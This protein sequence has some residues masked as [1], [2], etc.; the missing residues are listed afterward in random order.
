MSAQQKNLIF[1]ATY[2]TGRP[3]FFAVRFLTH[4]LRRGAA[5]QIGSD[6]IVL[7]LA[8]VTAED[9][10][11]YSKPISFWNGNLSDITGLTRKRLFSAREMCVKSGW[12]SYCEGA[13]GRAPVYF[14]TVPGGDEQIDSSPLGE[15]MADE[16]VREF[17]IRVDFGTQLGTNRELIPDS[18]GDQ[19]GTHSSLY[20]APKNPPPHSQL[21]GP[22]NQPEKREE[23]EFQSNI[24]E[25]WK[26]DVCRRLRGIG[27]SLA[28]STLNRSIEVHRQRGQ[29]VTKIVEVIRY[30]EERQ[31]VWKGKPLGPY[32]GGAAVRRLT[33][34]ELVELA[35][36]T[37]WPSNKDPIWSR[38]W[39]RELERRSRAAQAQPAKV[40]TENQAAER[41]SWRQLELQFQGEL[42]RLS[43]NPAA[44]VQMLSDAGQ[45]DLARYARKSP[46]SQVV[47][48]AVLRLLAG[49]NAG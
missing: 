38:E 46:D 45:D 7:L 8:I 12:L 5:F 22:G 32:G 18:I 9:R 16:I 27:V 29:D 11:R 40:E 13:R 35:A 42:Q 19:S 1:A 30:L 23:E 4:L 21:S 49:T 39:A 44:V 20:P 37:G 36:D 2:P 25:V 34:G 47:R 17:G 3:A 48:R 43:A 41:E 6:G 31:L 26:S 10:T 28:E 33:D 15:T 14:V 24:P